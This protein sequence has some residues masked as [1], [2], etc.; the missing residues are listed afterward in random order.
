MKGNPLN[1]LVLAARKRLCHTLAIAKVSLAET[2][3]ALPFHEVESCREIERLDAL[4]VLTLAALNTGGSLSVHPL[5]YSID[6]YSLSERET[7]TVE[8]AAELLARHRSR[9][10]RWCEIGTLLAATY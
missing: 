1:E 10:L 6:I 5:Q 7:V 9:V 2:A 8:E 4:I 3:A